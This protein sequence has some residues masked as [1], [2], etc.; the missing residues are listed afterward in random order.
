[1]QGEL[2]GNFLALQ[3]AVERTALDLLPRDP[4]RAK[5]LLADWSVSAGEQVMRRWQE[6][7]EDLFTKYNDGYVQDPAGEPGEEGYPE[8][9]LRQVIREAPGRFELPGEGVITSPANY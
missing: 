8:P 1:V 5:R 7:A 9:W 2:E 3:P 4:A 6:L